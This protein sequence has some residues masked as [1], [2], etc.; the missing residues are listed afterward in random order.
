MKRFLPIAAVLALSA[1]AHPKVQTATNYTPVWSLTCQRPNG[2]MLNLTRSVD[3]FRADA[4]AYKRSMEI[5]AQDRKGKGKALPTDFT[6]DKLTTQV[7]MDKLVFSYHTYVDEDTGALWLRGQV[8]CG[9]FEGD[10]IENRHYLGEGVLNMPIQI[11]D[12]TKPITP[13]YQYSGVGGFTITMGME[14]PIE[15]VQRLK[16]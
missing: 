11:P 8:S 1:C 9:R 16:K 6:P 7:G 13:K 5:A 3:Q 2:Y 12:L 4:R 10:T 15:T 14:T